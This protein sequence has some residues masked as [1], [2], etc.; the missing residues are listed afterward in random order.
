M[1]FFGIL[2][3]LEWYFSYGHFKRR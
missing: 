2:T 3:P 1:S